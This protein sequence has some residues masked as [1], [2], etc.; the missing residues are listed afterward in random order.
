[1]EHSYSVAI[2]EKSV[3]VS[4]RVKR[5]LLYDAEILLLDVFPR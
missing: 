1:M 5:N 3:A 4:Y 2:L